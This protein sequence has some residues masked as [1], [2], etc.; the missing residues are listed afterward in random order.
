MGHPSLLNP[1]VHFLAL[2]L[3]R[4]PA[5]ESIVRQMV[6][7]LLPSGTVPGRC[8]LLVASARGPQQV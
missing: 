2:P 7:I 8:A 5:E 1:S 3:S 6:E 4:L